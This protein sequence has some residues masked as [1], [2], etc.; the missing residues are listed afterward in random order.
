MAIRYWERLL[1]EAPDVPE[2]KEV[3][4]WLGEAALLKQD[5]RKGADIL[6]QLKGDSALYPQGLNSLGWYHFQRGEWKE[7][8]EYFLRLH[9]EYPQYQSA[10][11]TALMVAQCYL[12]QGNYQKAKPYLNW[13]ASLPEEKED[14]AK[15]LYLLGWI[16]Y[17][18][19]RFDEAIAQFQNILWSYPLSPYRPESQYWVGWSYF[20]KKDFQKA[21]DEF[22]SLIQYDAKG[23]FVP[24]ALQ[25]IG[26]ARFNLK[27]YPSAIQVYTRV[28]KVSEIE[29]LQR[30]IL[31][32][33]CLQQEKKYEAFVS[34]GE[35]I[36][37]RYPQHPLASQAL[38]QLADYYAQNQMKEKALKS[39][40]ELI[41]QY[42]NSEWSAEAHLRTALLLRQEKRWN[43]ATEGLER[44][45]KGYPK[46]HL[47]V[48]GSLELGE[49]YLLQKEYGKAVERFEKLIEVFRNILSPQGLSRTGRGYRASEMTCRRRNA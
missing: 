37:K 17:K 35:G 15:A 23:A 20:R 31:G 19:E 11:S 41:Q 28:V 36:V 42:P 33:S 46:S 3:L 40:R 38:M 34:Q 6:G 16:A 7:A 48:E 22:Q 9:E 27:D 30:Q 4:Y 18:E 24:S 21:I 13:L 14:R 47:F 32:S 10:P 26:D 39:Y 12:N 49:L 43:E 8:N 29:R 44:F 45:I 25:K 2:K 1:Q 5:Y